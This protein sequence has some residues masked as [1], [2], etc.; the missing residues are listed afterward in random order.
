M[1]HKNQFPSPLNWQ[2]NNPS[3]TFLP[4]NNNTVDKGSV[5]SGVLNGA[6]AGTNVI[7]SQIIDMSRMD[8]IGAEVN[9]SGTAIGTLEIMVSNSGANFYALTFNPALAQP[10]GSS[11]GYAIDL[12]QL[13]FK[14]IMFRY[15][16]ASGTGTLTIY[17]Q[18]KDLN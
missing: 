6:M 1:G 2:S 5:P 9:F 3:L 14:Y 11:G 12:N 10:S 4:T 16:N 13:P 17:L 7:Y 15:T 18:S 8:N